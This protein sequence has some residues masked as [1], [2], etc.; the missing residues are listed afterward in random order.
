MSLAAGLHT[1]SISAFGFN[2]AHS[3]MLLPMTQVVSI[4]GTVGGSAGQAAGFT[5]RIAIL[6]AALHAAVQAAEVEGPGSPAAVLAE[7]LLL[8]ALAVWRQLRAEQERL[9]AEEAQLFKTK[10]RA[11]SIMS[12]TVC[13]EQ[14]VALRGHSFARCF[15][16]T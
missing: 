16:I 4:A 11:N 13:W 6:R 9:A 12:E 3:V 14:G 7:S 1:G 8:S 5:A 2:T 15:P 10:T